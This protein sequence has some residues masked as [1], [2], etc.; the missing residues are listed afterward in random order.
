MD[1]EFRGSFKRFGRTK[2]CVQQC[3]FDS[4]GQWGPGEPTQLPTDCLGRLFGWIFLRIVD[5]GLASYI[6]VE[7]W[8]QAGKCGLNFG[9]SEPRQ[10]VL[11]NETVSVSKNVVL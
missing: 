3:V 1:L 4:P 6:V 7:G 2:N 9:N 10:R 5:F 8:P 11:L